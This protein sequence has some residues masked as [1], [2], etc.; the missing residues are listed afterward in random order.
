VDAKH[1]LAYKEAEDGQVL[2]EGITE[3]GSMASFTAAGTSYSSHGQ[4]MV[5]FF[6]FYSM[7]GFQ[8]IGDL[9]WSAADQRTRGFL[10]GATHGRTTLNGE[11]LQHQDGHSLLLAST[12]PAVL[13]YDPAFAYEI[14]VIV[15]EG[16][17]RMYDADEDLMY[18]LAVYNDPIPQPAKSDG[19]DEGIV[20]GLYRFR[21]AGNDR[22]RRA[23]IL[24]SGPMMPIALRAAELLAEDHEVAADVWSAPSYQQLRAEALE[25]ERWNR[26]H[27]EEARRTPFITSQLEG[28]EGPVVAVSDSMK[29]VPDQ[30]ARWV[31]QPYVSLGTD[32]FGRSDMRD[33][34]RRF[35][36]VDAEHV[37]VATL[38]ALAQM[39]EVKPEAVTEAIK[40]YGIDPDRPSA[41]TLP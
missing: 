30:V 1:L 22:P 25:V 32:G 40:K 26:L 27:P 11:G 21:E 13:A 29:A 8:R 12:N 24:G 39:G 35:F 7:F 17:R 28:A 4:P 38:S 41:P 18:Y 9:I 16:L 37:V 14:A 15:R 23:Q 20:K 6:S 36:E 2:E 33:T 34:L 31:P 3:A 19:V 10:L 5:P